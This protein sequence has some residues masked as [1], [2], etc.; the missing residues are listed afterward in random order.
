MTLSCYVVKMNRRIFPRRVA[1]CRHIGRRGGLLALLSLVASCG[2]RI[3]EGAG[4][5]GPQ[6]DPASRR[7]LQRTYGMLRC[8]L[9]EL[10]PRRPGM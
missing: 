2:A 4:R 8:L 1:R 5:K 9:G 10:R 3:D 6:D 7:A